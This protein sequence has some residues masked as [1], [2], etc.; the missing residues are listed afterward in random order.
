LPE[1]AF[2]A[3]TGAADI[4]SDAAGAVKKVWL[5]DHKDLDEVIDTDG[6]VCG[7]GKRGGV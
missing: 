4:Q 7:K 3:H 1:D 6:V 2:G 5:E